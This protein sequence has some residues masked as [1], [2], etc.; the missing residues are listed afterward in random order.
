MLYGENQGAAIGL[1]EMFTGL[2][3]AI[4]PVIGSYLYAWGGFG[5]PFIVYGSMLLGFSL[6]IK[7]IL[8]EHI[9][10]FKKDTR[11]ESEILEASAP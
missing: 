7:W 10:L 4:S 8:P 2:G 9:D 5:L 3:L 11:D 1:M 6:I